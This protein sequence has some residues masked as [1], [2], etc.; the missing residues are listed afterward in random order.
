M[1]YRVRVNSFSFI[2]LMLL[3]E[4][5]FEIDRTQIDWLT[6]NLSEL[7]SLAILSNLKT[8]IVP[9]ANVKYTKSEFRD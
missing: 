5:V 7:Q 9:V 3:F 4:Q 2:Y 8:S 1:R 6:H